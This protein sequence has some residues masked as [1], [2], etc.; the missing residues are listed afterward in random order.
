MRM[1]PGLQQRGL[2][3]ERLL[4]AHRVDGALE[5]G[6]GVGL[7]DRGERIGAVHQLPIGTH[8]FGKDVGDHAAQCLAR[9]G[10]ARLAVVPVNARFRRM[11]VIRRC[12]L[13]VAGQGMQ[14]AQNRFVDMLA[15]DARCRVVDRARPA[16]A[17]Q[18]G[19]HR[20]RIVAQRGR[21]GNKHGVIGAGIRRLAHSPGRDSQYFR[22]RELQLPVELARLPRHD[23]AGAGTQP[24]AQP[25]DILLL[26]REEH[27]PGHGS[28][29]MARAGERRI[30]DQRLQPVPPARNHR[31]DAQIADHAGERHRLADARLADRPQRHRIGDAERIIGQRIGDRDDAQ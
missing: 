26:V 1:L 8:R 28:G 27:E 12:R 5:R 23:R 19:L 11:R 29:H 25:V 16:D 17:A 14:K 31:H 18:A 10:N 21:R 2:A 22:M 15:G 9:G 30:V 3:D 13:L 6:G 20:V 4:V 7:V 24:H